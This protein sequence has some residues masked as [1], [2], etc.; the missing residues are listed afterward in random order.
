MKDG[1]GKKAVEYDGAREVDAF[2]AF[3]SK[4]LTGEMA[5]GAD[6]EADDL[7]L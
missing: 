5:V 2:K 4:L 3:I 1:A 7:E 6:G